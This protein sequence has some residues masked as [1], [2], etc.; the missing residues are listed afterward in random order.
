MDEFVMG[1][2]ELEGYRKYKR[3]VG[4][5][6]PAA[7]GKF[8]V[9]FHSKRRIYVRVNTIRIALS[10]PQRKINGVRIKGHAAVP[11]ANTHSARM[12]TACIELKPTSRL[13]AAGSCIV[14]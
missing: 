12:R 10:A 11:H 2:W 7:A 9:I 5:M 3:F 4:L 1:E 6:N 14:G 8:R 13:K